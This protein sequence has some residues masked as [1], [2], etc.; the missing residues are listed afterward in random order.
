MDSQQMCY[1]KQCGNVGYS[2][3][4]K[5]GSKAAALL[6]TPALIYR[7]ATAYYG[8]EKCGSAEVIP[9]N[10]PLAQEALAKAKAIVAAQG[11]IQQPAENT[12][13]AT[14]TTQQPTE[15]KAVVAAAAQQLEGLT[16]PRPAE[17]A[18]WE[19]TL[20]WA[21]GIMV[22]IIVLIGMLSQC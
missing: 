11:T 12:A 3:K 18:S 16:Q 14:E 8:C 9:V 19:T 4:I 21:L 2:T 6:F 22:L 1:C 20:L 17:P 10:S 7:A 5:K 13:V 15:E